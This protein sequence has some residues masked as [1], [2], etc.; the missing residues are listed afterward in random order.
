LDAPWLNP[1]TQGLVNILLRSHQRAFGSSL[2]AGD[3]PGSS[4]RLA[5][6]ELFA[7][8]TAVLA[9][10]GNSDPRLTYANAAAI[11]LWRRPWNDMVGMHS[12]LTAPASERQERAAALNHAQRRDAFQGYRGI[13]MDSEGRRFVI[14]NARI[15]TLWDEESRIC[16]QAAAFAS[17][18]WL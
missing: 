16:G 3:R 8:T 12:R 15:W 5:S 7:T 6:Q 9:H 14:N 18:W 17:W 4:R 11:R 13:R 1:E 2:L 10:D